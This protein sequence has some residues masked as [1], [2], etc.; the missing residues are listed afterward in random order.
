MLAWLVKEVASPYGDVAT[1]HWAVPDTDDNADVDALNSTALQ[2]KLE[3]A[4]DQLGAVLWNSNTAALNH[5]HT[6]IFVSSAVHADHHGART[7]AS[8]TA[9][10]LAGKNIVE[11]GA[12][13]GC[14]GIALAMAGAR[15]AITDLKELLPLMEHNARLNDRRVQ[16]RS[17]GAGRCVALQW[18]WGPTVSTG[19][20][21]QVQKACGGAR[22]PAPQQR[23]PITDADAVDR[24]VSA[25]AASLLK[26]SASLAGCVEAL[27]P[28]AAA[29]S[30]GAATT[31][32][33]FHYVILCDALYGNPKD[34]PALL[35]TL[36]ELMAT[37]PNECQVIN[38]CE[39][40][41]SDVEG[42]FLALL[43]AENGKTYV[44]MDQRLERGGDALWANVVES[45]MR[46]C[47]SASSTSSAVEQH[48]LR[49]EAANALLSYVL[50]QRRGAYRWT[51]STEVLQDAQ[52]DLN[53]VIRATQIRW[54]RVVSND[55]EASPATSRHPRRPREHDDDDDDNVDGSAPDGTPA[56]RHRAGGRQH[57][58]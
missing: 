32:C 38:F 23:L 41:V 49:E 27:Q 44:Q 5:L 39:Q 55:G 43:D 35:Y 29:T 12:G 26:P 37:N 18:K 48:A 8:S 3:S 57:R 19:V 15:V 17:G 28:T 46:C 47:R 16:S 9:A 25:M 14:L 24:V 31:Q 53:M 22:E 11:L 4:E 34:W 40:R 42:A 58:C 56:K 30:A 13:V 10:P 51:Y 33:R 36:T 21:K 50:V 6:N 20:H 54:T 52:S 45:A 7:D 1:L 2:V